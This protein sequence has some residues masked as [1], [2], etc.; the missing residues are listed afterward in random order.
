MNDIAG[1]VRKIVVAQLG[2]DEAI[3]T[4]DA[5]FVGDL[6]ADSL[7]AVELVL[8]FEHE[9]DCKIPDDAVA[10][11]ATVRGAVSF[12]EGGSSGEVAL[13]G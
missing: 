3:V 2:V 7:K 1:R 13:A 5:S 6:G 9:F 4:D 12:I 8:A 10:K 11:L